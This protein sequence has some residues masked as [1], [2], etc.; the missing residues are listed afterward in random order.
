[1]QK[2]TPERALIHTRI[3]HSLCSEA[4]SSFVLQEQEGVIRRSRVQSQE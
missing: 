1:M 4:L 2:H 3:G